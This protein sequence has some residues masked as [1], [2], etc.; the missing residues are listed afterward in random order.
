MGRI[1]NR[2]IRIGVVGAGHIAERVHL[3]LLNQLADVVVPAICDVRLDG[4]Q[5][6][7]QRFAIP[8]VYHDLLEMLQAEELDVV[9]VL[10]PPDS[11]AHLA[12]QVLE[13]GCHC[14][15]EKPLAM[16]TGQAEKV[17]R[18][19]EKTGL[20]LHVT[21]SFSYFPALRRARALA[22]SGALG[23]VVSVDIQYL[24]SIGGER[25]LEPGHW[26]NR[27]PGAIFYDITP[28]LVMLLLDFLGPID[29]VK[30]MTRKVSSYSHL[31]ADELRV[32][33]ATNRGLGSFYLSMNSPLTRYVVTIMGTKMGLWI[34]ADAQLVVK[35]RPVGGY[36][37]VGSFRD[38]IPRG[39]GMAS[40]IWQQ[41]AGL[42]SI[43][44][45][46]ISGRVNYLSGHRYLI[47]ASLRSLQGR[48]E[49][50][51]DPHKCLEVVRV[52]EAIFG[53]PSSELTGQDYGTI[54][55]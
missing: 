51:V 34:N 10:T 30:V 17:I 4:A 43:S 20:A 33:A 9:D 11:H 22:A 38:A 5:R 42:A 37:V 40:E 3:P 24:T 26:C 28:H 16:T 39:L 27:M 32:M 44:A 54:Q 14:L 29:D 50:P 2:A 46:V 49:Y 55:R 21:H 18:V 45:R 15:M 25:Y 23:E 35:L 19:A 1:D 8:M 36:K 13:R 6:L 47:E 31:E 41:A 52:L 53:Q 12:T 48:G 7:A